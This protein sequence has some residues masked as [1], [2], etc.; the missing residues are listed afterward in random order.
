MQLLRG[1][2]EETWPSVES[3]VCRQKHVRTEGT[4]HHWQTEHHHH[5][6]HRRPVCTNTSRN[7][8]EQF[9]RG[10]SV[11]RVSLMNTVT[12]IRHTRD[13]AAH[14]RPSAWRRTA[15]RHVL[16]LRTWRLFEKTIKVLV[17]IS[18]RKQAS[19]SASSSKVSLIGRST[20]DQDELHLDWLSYFISVSFLAKSGL[21]LHNYFH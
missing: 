16:K 10:R 8:L 15:T 14:R 9:S 1:V 21:Q 20:A 13:A 6:L 5:H 17:K 2:K 18:L 4:L 12:Q 11:W 7:R 3:S 19:S